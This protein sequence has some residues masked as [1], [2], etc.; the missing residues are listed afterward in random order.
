MA[1]KLK[2]PVRNMLYGIAAAAAVITL[3]LLFKMLYGFTRELVIILEHNDRDELMRF[4][5]EKPVWSGLFAL[6]VM[7][8]LQVISIVLPG[9]IIQVSG[10]LI[11]GWW[12]SFLICWFGFVSGNALIFIA[13][14]IMKRS[15]TEAFRIESKSGWLIRE[16]NRHD[17]S[18]VTA[19]ACMIPG[20]PN[21][22]IPYIASRTRLYLH[23][24]VIAVA[25]SCWIQILLNCIA[26]HF[27]VRGEYRF[28]V[29]AFGLQIVILAVMTKYR[30]TL[31]DMLSRFTENLKKKNAGK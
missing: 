9:M 26:G 5:N 20:I 12:K 27:L 2:K 8:V 21:G 31:F 24:F 19:F 11:F 15:I 28:T 29:F 25:S 23:Q 17:P 4:I 3:L 1:R 16:M 18:F 7:S 6:Y 30:E 14:R 10:A 22:I 13:A